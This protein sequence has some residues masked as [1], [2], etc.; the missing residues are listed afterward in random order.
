M[1]KPPNDRSDDG[2]A[3]TREIPSGARG[4]CAGDREQRT[5]DFGGKPA[6]GKDACHDHRRDSDGWR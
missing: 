6:E 1:W 2:D 4:N 5:W 3:V